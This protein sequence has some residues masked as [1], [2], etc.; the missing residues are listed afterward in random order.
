MPAAHGNLMGQ[1]RTENSNA[2]PARTAFRMD[3]RT[4]ISLKPLLRIQDIPDS[5]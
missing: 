3:S 1:I 4:K 5:F 2:E